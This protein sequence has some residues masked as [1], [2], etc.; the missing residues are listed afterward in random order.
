M[1]AY[2]RHLMEPTAAEL[3]ELK[4]ILDDT[5]HLVVAP[6]RQAVVG[7]ALASYPMFKTFLATLDEASQSSRNVTVKRVRN[8]YRRRGEPSIILQNA[9]FVKVWKDLKH[10]N[11]LGLLGYTLH[12][13][14]IDQLISP[15]LINGNLWDFLNQTSVGVAQRLGFILTNKPPFDES[16]GM[17]GYISSIFQRKAPGQPDM[18]LSLVP[19]APKPEY[20]STLRL[21]YSYLPL[22]WEY[23]PNKRPPIS[24]LRRQVFMFSFEDDVGDSVVATLEELA[25]LLIPPERLRI[26]ERSEL[27]E[28]N[29]GEVVL[30]TLDEASST[31]RDVAVKRLKAV[32]TRGE[33]VRLAKRLA[34]ELNIWAKIKHSNVVELIGYYLDEKYEAPLLISALMT[35]GNV[36]DY[37]EHYKP[38][39]EQRIGFVEG[40]TA[41]LAC[42]HDFDPAICHADLKPAN[43]LIDLQMNAVLCDFGLASF[44]S[45][46]AG[47][48]GLAT[49]TSLKGTPRY[50]SPE[51]LMHSDCKHNLESDVLTGRIPYAE[52]TGDVQF[53]LAINQGEIPGDVALLL[54]NA[55]EVPGVATS[56]SKDV[57]SG[58]T[59]AQNILSDPSSRQET[60]FNGDEDLVSGGLEEGTKL[61]RTPD[62]SGNCAGIKSAQEDKQD[63]PAVAHPEGEVVNETNPMVGQAGSAINAL[64]S[65]LPDSFRQPGVE[66]SESKDVASGDTQAQQVLW[67]P[68]S[69]Q[70]TSFNED[71]ASGG[72]EEGTK[73][74]ET[75]EDPSG[76]CAG[77]KSAQEDQQ[78][79]PAVAHLEGEVVNETNPMVGQAGTAIKGDVDSEARFEDD[80]PKIPSITSDRS[81]LNISAQTL[82]LVAVCIVCTL[83]LL[84]N[85]FF[86][87][88]LRKVDPLPLRVREAT[89]ASYQE[90]D[91]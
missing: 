34:R 62:P 42:L 85:M 82:I 14:M 33:R 23:E 65:Q 52:I 4:V 1:S 66:T 56:G 40:I 13:N 41:G 58:D 57:A 9:Q 50:M 80:D 54:P 76:N 26:V 75:P 15:Y 68:P 18:L 11:V 59:Q 70:E 73:L 90:R 43:V 53:Y 69:R 71:I 55:A 29:Y 51:L 5:A 28:G 74:A 78:D 64:L 49:T 19:D 39:I 88:V 44:V 77:V 83:S 6:E 10:P 89:R 60:S 38:D 37:I 46:S 7:D 67:D 12:E 86:I 21:L 32:G 22:C 47:Q 91:L 84:A 27:G 31:P 20:A 16:E 8:F 79:I 3:S 25:H 87:L 48:A 36:L 30:G 61:A 17:F 63:I 81:A 45:G 24:L 2:H 35:N 72:L